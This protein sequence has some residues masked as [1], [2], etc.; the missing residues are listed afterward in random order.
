MS[1]IVG[2][3]NPLNIN[4]EQIFSIEQ[5]LN[6]FYE[7][8][9]NIIFNLEQSEKTVSEFKILSKQFKKTF[10]HFAVIKVKGK[11]LIIADGYLSI[12]PDVKQLSL[13]IS[14]TINGAKKYGIDTPKVAVLSAVEVVSPAMESAIPASVMEAMGKRGQF[15][16]GVFVEG[17]LSI[18]VALSEKSAKEKKV[19]T[20]VAGNANILIGHKSTI[21]N[22]ILSALKLFAAP[23]FLISVVTDGENF[24]PY[25]L[26]IMNEQDIEKTIKFCN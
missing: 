10:S 1:V 20:D 16:K 17:P 9:T 4:G 3:N 5:A 23:E 7:N 21:P 18:D 14:N 22:G 12:L 8:K 13:I 25:I 24:F 15:G 26:D 2:N 11:N 19:S 6:R